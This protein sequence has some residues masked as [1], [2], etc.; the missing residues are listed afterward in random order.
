MKPQ[1]LLLRRPSP[2]SPF[3]TS[4]PA[5][6]SF[7]Q[8]RRAPTRP[9]T[10]RPR[11]SPLQSRI[12]PRPKFLRKNSGGPWP[13]AQLSH[14]RGRW[15][16][17]KA[18]VRKWPGPRRLSFREKRS[19]SPRLDFRTVPSMIDPSSDRPKSTD[20]RSQLLLQAGAQGQAPSWL[21]QWLLPAPSLRGRCPRSP[22]TC[23]EHVLCGSVFFQHPHRALSLK[24]AHPWLLGFTL[25]A[26]NP[27]S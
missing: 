15:L 21:G 11:A 10:P 18:E 16:G 14:H 20:E 17:R 26:K 24:A 1:G 4:A 3:L 25:G 23:L 8:P 27:D 5:P 6:P 19:R 7:S 13:G 9:S 2:A 22:P 12:S